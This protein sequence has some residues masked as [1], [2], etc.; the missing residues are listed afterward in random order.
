MGE[1]A[2]VIYRIT[3]TANG[4]C[5]VGS[6]A[7]PAQRKRQHFHLLRAGR[8]HSRH[9]QRAYA[10]H[11]ESALAWEIIEEVAGDLLAAE[12]RLIASLRPRFNSGHTHPTRLGARHSEASKARMSEAQ[13]ARGARHTDASRAEIGA[14]SVGNRYAA[15]NANARKVTPEVRGRIDDLRGQGM[16]CR[17]IARATGL[18]KTTILNVFNGRT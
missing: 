2:G 14:A 7:Q 18:N 9:L 6:T 1:I 15:G 13:R 3:C 4:R 5:Y 12:A 17:R 11:G 16:G 8:H 10:K